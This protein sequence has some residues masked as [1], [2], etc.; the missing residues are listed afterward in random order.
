MSSITITKPDDWHVHFR[1]HEFLKE[2]VN[3]TAANFQRA[4]VMPN[5]TP[6]LTSI[7]DIENYRN[8][9][10]KA[11]VSNSTFTPI[12][13]FYLNEALSSEEIYKAKASPF[14]KGCKLYP[15]GATTN[16]MA[17]VSS[18]KS[19]YPKLEAMQDAGL[20]L[21]IHGEVTHSDIFARE[22]LF[23]KEYLI[24]IVKNF[25]KLKIILEH[26]STKAA[27][28]YIEAAPENVGATITP[29]HLLYNR[30]DLLV[31]GIKPHFYCL[32]IL[33]KDSDQK[34]LIKAATQ[35]SNKFF[36]GTDSAPHI[37]NAKESS[38]GCAGIYSA[39]YALQL[40]TQ[41]FANAQAF[42]HLNT[43]MS[44]TG[45]NFY[46]L[47][48]NKETITLVNKPTKI[49]DTLPLGNDTVVP[50]G[51]GSTLNWSVNE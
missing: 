49:K 9:I 10:C 41:V 30:N 29:Q 42:K 32:P 23:I 16:S 45:A 25:P 19:L 28:D 35:G 44:V 22:E 26:I 3:A 21:Q 33:K 31:G 24:D 15:K 39:P 4:L 1:D 8:R 7:R 47:A 37:K 34:A 2:T 5:L 18:V 43:F 13:T 17:G 12:M 40:Y 20:I 14:I 51:A 6:P 48:K 36:A 50:I 11:L 46:E 38:C 27:V